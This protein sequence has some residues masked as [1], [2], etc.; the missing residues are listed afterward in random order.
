MFSILRELEPVKIVC[1]TRT[2]FASRLATI[3]DLV[4]EM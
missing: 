3:H 4:I 1:R 2:Y